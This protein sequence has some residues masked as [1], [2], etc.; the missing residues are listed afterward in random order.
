MKKKYLVLLYCHFYL[1]GVQAGY[2]KETLSTKSTVAS[3]VN[4]RQFSVINNSELD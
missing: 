1:S 3:S 4:G 2:E